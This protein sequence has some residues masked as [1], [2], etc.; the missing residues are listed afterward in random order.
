MIDL[1]G[2]IG[3]YEKNWIS[4][5]E[6]DVDKKK[7]VSFSNKWLNGSLLII[8]CNSYVAAISG[9]TNQESMKYNGQDEICCDDDNNINMLNW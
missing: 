4:S 8:K 1:D 3:H 6:N 7:K 5:F 9:Q 2:K